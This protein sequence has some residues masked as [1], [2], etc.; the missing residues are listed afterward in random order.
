MH[1]ILLDFEWRFLGHRNQVKVGSIVI[2]E[3]VGSAI[4]D[5]ATR[6][7]REVRTFNS[8]RVESLLYG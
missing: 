8:A 5:H 2:K 6:Q 4:G 1:F 7:T 3:N